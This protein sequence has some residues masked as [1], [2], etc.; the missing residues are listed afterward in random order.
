MK[1][2]F[3]ADEWYPYYS[4]YE[5]ELG[6]DFPQ[7]EITEALYEEIV[8]AQQAIEKVQRKLQKLLKHD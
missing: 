3:M 2:N 6:S 4:L 7:V 5:H 8:S 1:V